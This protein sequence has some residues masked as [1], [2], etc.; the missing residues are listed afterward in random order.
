[1]QLN[2][3]N[4]SLEQEQTLDKFLLTAQY[5]CRVIAVEHNGRI[6]PKAEYGSTRLSDDDT[7]E[8]VRFVGG[9]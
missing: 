7:L 3:R 2:G 8:I 1:M 4:V 6:V 5:D 9:G